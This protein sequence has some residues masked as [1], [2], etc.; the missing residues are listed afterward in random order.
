ML[1][2]IV[3]QLD[4]LSNGSLGLASSSSWPDMVV[5][6]VVHMVWVCVADGRRIYGGGP[7]RPRS[8]HRRIPREFCRRGLDILF[9]DST[10]ASE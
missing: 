1:R 8:P 6:V 5:V 10:S 4:A 3:G 7:V 9:E 2:R